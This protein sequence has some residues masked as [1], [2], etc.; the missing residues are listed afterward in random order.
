MNG[1][2]EERKMRDKIEGFG[3]GSVIQH[4]KM[5]NRVY[6]MKLNKADFPA[7]I[8][9]V[10]QLAN[11][12]SY[13]KIFCKVPSWA[14]PE[15]IS[16]GFIVEAHIP[17]FYHNRT[18]VF[19]LSKFTDSDR[20]RKIEHNELEALTRELSSD[21]IHEIPHAL[22]NG[23]SISA[24]GPEQSQEIAGLYGR[25]FESYPFP[26]HDPDYILQTIGSHIRYFGVLHDHQLVALA[27]AETDPEGGNAEMTD[28]ATLPEFRGH[29]LSVI[30]LN[31]MEQKMK[32]Q[33]ISTLYTIARL[34]STAMNKTFLKL[35]YKYA[36]TLIMNTNISGNMESMN[37]YYKH[38]HRKG[39]GQ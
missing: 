33:G 38:I 36:G 20:L 31:T 6:L 23:F 1:S 18:D 22:S 26:I 27:S 4:G 29:N 10:S 12:N 8:D 24:L 39:S 19:F 21:M 32:E 28:F 14:A 30:L 37:V 2:K 5:N 9:H 35:K 13:T 17:D 25:V 3:K 7:V 11:A 16:N 34:N 15:F